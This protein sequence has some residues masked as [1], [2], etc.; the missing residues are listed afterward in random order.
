M[1]TLEAPGALETQLAAPPPKYSSEYWYMHFS[2][3]RSKGEALPWQDPYRLDDGERRTVARS[4]Q[5]FQIGE[6]ARGRGFIRRARAHPVFACDPWFV[7]ALELFIAEE[8]NH[9]EMLGRFL[10]R[11]QIPRLS[12]NLADSVF[13]RLRKLAGLEACAAVLVTAE[14]MAVPF[15][16]ALRD[17]TG[18]RLL[19]AIC[20]RVLCEEATH[21]TYQARTLGLIH[22][23]LSAR[24][25][26]AH[27][28]LHAILFRGTALLVWCEHRRVFRAAGWNLQ[29]FRAEANRVFFHLQ[30]RIRRFAES[31]RIDGRNDN[32]LD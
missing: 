11:E 2:E 17:A 13:R 7:P 16:Q 12:H 1:T 10:D 29:S 30:S 6:W 26:R 18:S 32:R 9:S 27:S 31:G 5:Q 24:S 23:R 22:R 14:V 3:N 21:L 4:I 25:R 28:V 8:Q 19:R 15:Y 20:V